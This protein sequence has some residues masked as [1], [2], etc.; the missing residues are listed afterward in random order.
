MWLC[1]LNK[2]S[3]WRILV[4]Q[5]SF[6]AK[7]ELNLEVQVCHGFKVA[8]C[9]GSGTSKVRNHR[10]HLARILALPRLSLQVLGIYTQS[11]GRGGS[12][13]ASD[14]F[15]ESGLILVLV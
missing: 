8:L 12:V 4:H 2:K 13:D 14:V 11:V 3:S 1:F 15:T 9:F 5:R 6:A 7:R 10:L